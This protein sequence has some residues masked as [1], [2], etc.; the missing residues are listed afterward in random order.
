MAA[1]GAI[2]AVA[3]AFVGEGRM[4]AAAFDALG[5]LEEQMERHDTPV[6]AAI[7]PRRTGAD[8]L[9]GAVGGPGDQ[10]VEEGAAFFPRT[11]NP[12]RTRPI[13]QGR[14]GFGYG[15]EGGCGDIE[16][17]IGR[18]LLGSWLRS[19]AHRFRRGYP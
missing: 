6:L 12:G 7:A 15:G 1:G 3:I 19:G 5:V 10:T 2:V 14:I 13:L 8:A 9:L 18:R 11:A 17:V 4:E 16:P